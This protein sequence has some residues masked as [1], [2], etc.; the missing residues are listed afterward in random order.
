MFFLNRHARTAERHRQR[1]FFDHR[2][3]RVHQQDC[4]VGACAVV[5]EIAQQH[6]QQRAADGKDRPAEL[7]VGRG[8]VVG[9]H[10]YGREKHA[11]RE[12]MHQRKVNRL[13]V[14]ISEEEG[15]DKD[16]RDVQQRR[17]R[18]DVLA[19]REIQI[20]QQQHQH[21]DFA[22]LARGNA[23]ELVPEVRD[24]H[25]PV[26]ELIQRSVHARRRDGSLGRL[27]DV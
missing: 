25:A 1:V 21:A 6:R 10:E 13:A 14:A 19:E 12:N 9:A 18:L 15:N 8:R 3:Q 17:Q 5:A 4:K 24:V 2:R 27:E 7:G 22:Q 26:G 23:V 16:R 20:A 11:A